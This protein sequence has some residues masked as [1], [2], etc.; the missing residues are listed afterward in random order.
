MAAKDKGAKENCDMASTSFPAGC[1]KLLVALAAMLAF[2]PSAAFPRPSGAT[3]KLDE[4]Y[5]KRLKARG[6]PI[7]GSARAPDAAL[8]VARDIIQNM[9][10]H[11]SDIRRDMA[12][13]GVRVAVIAPE[14]GIM[15][16]PEYR[17]WRKPEKDDPRLTACERERYGELIQPLSH[18]DYWNRRARGIGGLVTAAG[19]ENLLALPGTAYFGENILIHEFAHQILTSIERVDQPL[20]HRVQTAYR[21]ALA[22]GKWKGDYAAVTVQEYWAEGTQFWFNTNMLSRM[23]DGTILSPDDLRRYDA[24]LYR[25]LKQVYGPRHKI[26]ADPFYMHLARLNVPP[27]RKSADC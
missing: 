3:T 12:D 14:E 8:K 2:T 19:A 10:A 24:E 6:I 26:A 17:H 4:F 20:F 23:E 1:A 22:F 25:T 5:V 27:G 16:L 11:R 15:D 13:R 18:R 9:L 7:T 21:N